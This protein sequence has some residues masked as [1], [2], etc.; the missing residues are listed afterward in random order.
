MDLFTYRVR[1]FHR[2]K[3]VVTSGDVV[4]LELSPR[5]RRESS[6]STQG[7]W[8][9]REAQSS[10]HTGEFTCLCPTHHSLHT[11]CRLGVQEVQKRLFDCGMHLLSAYCLPGIL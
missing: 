9:P 1:E 8:E 4:L 6:F 10:V 11:S 5:W 3:G 2:G 7:F